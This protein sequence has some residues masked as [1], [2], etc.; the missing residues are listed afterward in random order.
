M[1]RLKPA[2]QRY[3]QDPP[4]NQSQFTDS[5]NEDPPSQF[6]HTE[7]QGLRAEMEEMHSQMAHS[8]LCFTLNRSNSIHKEL[9]MS[10]INI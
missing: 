3:V 4:V 8:P 1:Q 7:Q 9:I 10:L 2:Q 5:K 6:G